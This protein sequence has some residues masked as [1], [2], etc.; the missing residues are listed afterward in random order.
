MITFHDLQR[1]LNLP[2]FDGRQAQM[3]MAPAGRN[4]MQPNP[5]KAPRQSAVLVL[6]Y[7]EVGAGL[8]LFLTRR[9]EHLR[10]HSG[11]ISFP[12]GRCDPDDPHLEYTALRETREEL[13]I[14]QDHIRVVG[15]LTSLWIPPSNYDVH[16]IVGTMTHKPPVVPSPDE[17]AEVLPLPL[18]QLLNPARKKHTTMY[19]ANTAIDVPYYDVQGHVVW[20]ATGMM[21]SELEQRLRRALA[22]SLSDDGLAS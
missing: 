18:P 14:S 19:I 22:A 5:H 16:P 21:L 3:K 9:T 7:P 20:G 1:A 6:V 11:Q 12:G 13:G 17:V 2:N 15:R 10:G 4:R 8:H